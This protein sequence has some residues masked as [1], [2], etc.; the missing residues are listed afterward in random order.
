MS[1]SACMRAGSFALLLN[2]N[3]PCFNPEA[4]HH[5]RNG[6][7]H[8]YIYRL[9][10]Y[11]RPHCAFKRKGN[12]KAAYVTYNEHIAV[13]YFQ[14]CMVTAGG[15]GQ[16]ASYSKSLC[17]NHSFRFHNVVIWWCVVEFFFFFGGTLATVACAVIT[18]D[19]LPLASFAFHNFALSL[20]R[21]LL[22]GKNMTFPGT[23]QR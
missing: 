8:K 3:A 5:A 14:K 15:P 6:T 12:N 17:A 16:W 9:C 21:R 18:V 2:S 7:A 13:C 20:F 10:A 23:Q 22:L 11:N 1:K 4:A 19:S